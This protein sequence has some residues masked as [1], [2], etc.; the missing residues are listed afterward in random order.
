M[1]FS[2]PA[3]MNKQHPLTLVQSLAHLSRE[4]KKEVLFRAVVK[5][6][7]F[8][9]VNTAADSV[10]KAAG[11]KMIGESWVP[12]SLSTPFRCLDNDISFDLAYNNV[13]TSLKGEEYANLLLSHVE[14]NAICL[15]NRDVMGCL[16]QN[17]RSTMRMLQLEKIGRACFASLLKINSGKI[18]T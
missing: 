13:R 12:L 17:K 4:I 11:L 10:A 6:G 3:R 15:T 14:D 18:L 7:D 8:D 9:D 16:F 5:Y 1:H 2:E